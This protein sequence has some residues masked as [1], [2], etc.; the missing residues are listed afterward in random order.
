GWGR[1]LNNDRQFKNVDRHPKFVT[2]NRYEK[3]HIGN[4][5]CIA[6]KGSLG[7][8]F[9]YNDYSDKSYASLLFYDIT[10]L[11]DT[12]M[13][14][15]EE[16]FQPI[17][18]GASAP[19]HMSMRNPTLL[20]DTSHNLYLYYSDVAELPDNLRNYLWKWDAENRKWIDKDIYTKHFGP[21][22]D[23]DDHIIPKMDK[24]NNMWLPSLRLQPRFLKYNV[25]TEES[26][27][28]DLW[29]TLLASKK[30]GDSAELH[31]KYFYM[32]P[33][34]M[35]WMTFVRNIYILE[36]TGD[37]F[38]SIYLSSDN[39]LN[40]EG[41]YGGVFRFNP[42]DVAN[43]NDLY[44]FRKI[45]N[46][47]GT[48]VVI[49]QY[50]GNIYVIEFDNNN[51]LIKLLKYNPNTKQFEDTKIFNSIVNKKQIEAFVV[52][53]SGNYIISLRTQGPTYSE[54]EECYSA[55]R[56]LRY[57]DKDGKF[58]KEIDVPFNFQ[59][60]NIENVVGNRIYFNSHSWNN[61]GKYYEEEGEWSGLYW[62]D[63]LD[64]IKSIEETAEAGLLPDIWILS[65]S[66]NPASTRVTANIMYY[67]PSGVFGS[68]EF[69]VGLYN[70]LGQKLI[71]LTHLGSYSDYNKTFEV[72]FDIPNSIN[73][74]AYFISVKNGK[75]IKSKPLSI[76]RQR[77]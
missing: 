64:A 29:D 5:V 16:I 24:N 55:V 38:Y 43:D 57:H 27:V 72:T 20:C 74:G 68:E 30:Y 53:S 18:E 8:P 66:P 65:I 17:E 33:F 39:E 76:V 77:E 63:G 44:D 50:N 67:P 13:Q 19:S 34:E 3:I 73:N 47:K 70:I 2:S 21:I 36:E 4:K 11:G 45:L 71:D 32:C 69:D 31:S 22:P 25:D 12:S 26:I 23:I 42:N 40:L 48:S 54:E 7:L 1:I 59:F 9:R 6:K 61:I 46:K 75:K 10:E 56:K 60:F 37:I 62:F 51:Y 41:G 49:T 28:I 58:I 52:D 35:Q 15:I 14:F